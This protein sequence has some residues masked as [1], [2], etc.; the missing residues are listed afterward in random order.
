MSPRRGAGEGHI[1]RI[2]LRSGKTA[3]RGWVT[4][5]YRPN[6]TPIRRT[7][8]RRTRAA[9]QEALTRLRERY[10]I[11]EGLDLDAEAAM[12]LH[13]LLDRWLAHFAA[14][15]RAK[16]RTPRTY[17]WGV[18]K[19]KAATP[20]NPLV[21]RQTLLTLQDILERLPVDLAEG[22]LSM[23]RTVLKLAFAQAVVW[24]IRHDN[25]AAGLKIPRRERDDPERRIISPDQAA[26]LLRALSEERLGLAIA[27]TYAIAARPGEVCALRRE[28]VDLERG[29][30]TITATH[31]PGP[32]GGVV[33]ERP[34]S[35]R[36][37]RTL[38][39]PADIRPW[40]ARQI[41]R[42]L[43]E[44]AAMGAEWT[45]PDEGLL[46]VRESDG[47]RLHA[48]GLYHTAR[49]IAEAAGLG[50]VTP[51]IL[52]RSMLSTLGASGVDPKVRAAIGG[53][54]TT[55]TEKHYREVDQA[56]IDR[57]MAGVKLEGLE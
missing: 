51:R 29:T 28:D 47:G 56:E 15:S 25:P 54:T 31:N 13:E 57:A 22:S 38:P 52:R 11:G 49:T 17:A 16:S 48:G 26:Q 40:V 14:T 23:C 24:R 8:Q 34:K 43:N 44:R 6:G 5:G 7:A 30:V 10:N 35:R 32:G 21:A 36:G 18:E 37:V 53:H 9:V 42:S 19:I 33:R 46:F 1:K 20:T 41:A 39:L 3:W 50:N 12:R 4:V 2:T 55:V 27:L 45:A